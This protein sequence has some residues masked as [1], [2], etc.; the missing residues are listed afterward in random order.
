MRKKRFFKRI[1]AVV[2]LVSFSVM[3]VK[4][5]AASPLDME[6]GAEES[7]PELPAAESQMPEAESQIPETETTE[8]QA[9]EAETVES[10]SLYQ[11]GEFPA[12]EELTLYASDRNRQEAERAIYGSLERVEETLELSQFALTPSEVRAAVVNVVNHSPE[13]FYVGNKY[14]VQYDSDGIVHS[15]QWRD[16]VSLR[17]DSWPDS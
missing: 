17:R 7:A 11:F 4:A 10:V 13:L 1:I 6:S 3:P 16:G 15:V 5:A 14:S 8:P 12:E 2:A 9:P